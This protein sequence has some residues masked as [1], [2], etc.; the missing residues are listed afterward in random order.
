MAIALF[1][2]RGAFGS[3]EAQ[4]GLGVPV[5]TTAEAE[6][7][8]DMFR[9]FQGVSGDILLGRLHIEHISP[10]VSSARVAAHRP[11]F[12]EHGHGGLDAGVEATE[13]GGKAPFDGT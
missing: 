10:G 3:Q 13:F 4:F 8:V 7:A 9:Q 1:T 6:A 2:V 5:S 11:T 12:V